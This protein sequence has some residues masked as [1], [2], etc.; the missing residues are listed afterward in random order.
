MKLTD[1][2]LDS[3]QCS[4]KGP[5][6]LDQYCHRRAN[7]SLLLFESGDGLRLIKD[8]DS[9]DLSDCPNTM[10]KEHG[11]VGALL[12]L[13]PFCG[14]H[15]HLQRKDLSLMLIKISRLSDRCF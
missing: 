7:I 12:G 9:D 1:W 15:F 8:D 14:P 3:V 4:K 13:F 2:L 6:I 5:P 11:M 10:H